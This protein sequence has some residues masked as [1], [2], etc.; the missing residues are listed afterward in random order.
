M[1]SEIE[2]LARQCHRRWLPKWYHAFT[3][4]DGL[5]HERLDHQFLPIHTGR[6][7]LLTQCR[8]LAIYAHASVVGRPVNTIEELI[9]HYD[10]IYTHFYVPHTT[11]WLFAIDDG[12]AQEKIYDLYAHA[13]V[14]FM[15][16]WMFRAT[17][18]E[19]FH[20]DAVQ[21][22]RFLQDKFR[23]DTGFH[24]QLD[25]HLDPIL[26]MRRQDPHMHLLEAALFAYETWRSEEDAFL[27]H[28]LVDVFHNHF[29]DTETH[30]MGENYDTS[31]NK[32]PQQGD[33]CEAG[34]HY[35]WIW[36][37]HRYRSA[38]QSGNKLEFVCKSLLDFAN[39]YGFDS[40]YGG[41]YDAVDRQGNVLETDKRIWPLTEAIKANAIMLDQADDRNKIKLTM[42]NIT[43]ILSTGYVHKRGF[44]TETLNRDLT[45][46]TDY[47]PGTTP[48]HLYFGIM[49][50][51]ALLKARGRSKSMRSGF[52]A[53]L[54]W[55]RR[56]L[57]A[58]FKLIWRRLFLRS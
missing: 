41:I 53:F 27:A 34:H 54:Y 48:Y 24:E 28:E 1:L 20:R 47:M 52:T 37:L 6:L 4:E 58:N 26:Q 11:G 19:R 21:T 17:G 57:S 9:M 5:F 55:L 33:Y 56:G 12:Q 30:S 14:I 8:Q 32:H 46:K 29:W 36:L 44:W 51:M 25:H 50:C 40:E 35:E 13:F 7:R 49:E 18:Q 16:V 22:R 45:P 3:R 43:S 2:N 23:A 31:L 15:C 10:S 39:K 42:R 38:F